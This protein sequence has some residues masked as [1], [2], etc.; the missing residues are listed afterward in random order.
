MLLNGQISQVLKEENKERIHISLNK[1]ETTP[2]MQKV[3]SEEI[4]LIYTSNHS[5]NQSL[6]CKHHS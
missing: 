3:M 6:C 5:K 2:D 1:L 4:V